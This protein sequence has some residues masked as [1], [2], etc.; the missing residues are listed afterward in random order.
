MVQYLEMIQYSKNGGWKTGY[1]HKL[2][3]LDIIYTQFVYQLSSPTFSSFQLV[4]DF[5]TATVCL[6]W[7]MNRWLLLFGNYAEASAV[8]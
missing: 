3:I 4:I 6:C 7:G 8:W 2:D 5:V 1:Q